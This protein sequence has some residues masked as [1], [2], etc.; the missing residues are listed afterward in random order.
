MTA[1]RYATMADVPRLIELARQEHAMS[2]WN[3]EPFSESATADTAAAF[4]RGH[5]RTVLMGEASYL[6]GMVQPMGFSNRLIAMEY[7]WFAADGMGMALLRRFELWARNMGAAR[8]VVHNYTNDRRMTMPLVRRG[9]Y[10][11][12][13]TALVKNLGK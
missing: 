11:T 8:M 12:M 4:I 1:I 5:G 13:G 10:T 7:A 9:G 6:A 3:A 2:D